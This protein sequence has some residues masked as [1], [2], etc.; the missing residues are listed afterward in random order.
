MR[1][2]RS[3]GTYCSGQTPQQHVHEID[4]YDGLH[5]P[6]VAR[7]RFVE[8]DDAESDEYCGPKDAI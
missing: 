8:R 6:I 1:I 4:P 2:I 7:S 3:D 5:A